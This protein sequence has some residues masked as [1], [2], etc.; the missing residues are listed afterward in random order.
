MRPALLVASVVLLLA[1]CVPF[2]HAIQ[3]EPVPEQTVAAP[4]PSV[5]T[6]TPVPT[7]TET[8]APPA[9]P[10]VDAGTVANGSYAVASGTGSATISFTREGEIGLIASLDCENCTGLV[11]LTSE[12][13]GSPWG[14]AQA[15]MSGEYLVDAFENTPAEQQLLLTAEGDW[16]ITISSWNDIE[17]VTGKQSGTGSVVLGLSDDGSK[18]KITYEPSDEADLFMGRFFSVAEGGPQVFGNEDAFTETF[19]TALPG[20]LAIMTNG[21]WTVT[22]VS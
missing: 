18:V 22:P 20:I 8:V 7:P 2:P 17:P 1:G 6:P 5:E 21:S 14:E 16:T 10:I 3:P 12:G 11:T 15:P 4:P 9:G 19:D 13:R